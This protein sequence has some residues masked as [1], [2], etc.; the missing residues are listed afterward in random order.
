MLRY[1]ENGEDVAF[2][3][4]FRDDDPEAGERWAA[5]GLR[6]ELGTKVFRINSDKS[7]TRVSASRAEVW[8]ERARAIS[9][10]EAFRLA[11]IV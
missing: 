10:S 9:R 7:L 2:A 8:L 6:D 5:E 11:G 1:F 4:E 3:V